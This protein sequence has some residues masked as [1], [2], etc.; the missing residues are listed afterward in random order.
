MHNWTLLKKA[1]FILLLLSTLPLTEIIGQGEISL[2]KVEENHSHHHHTGSSYYLPCGGNYY[3]TYNGPAAGE[4]L[5]IAI[6][7]E[8]NN[9]LNLNT[10]FLAQPGID[11][12]ISTPP[13]QLILAPNE[14]THLVITYIPPPVYET[15]TDAVLFI[16]D[17][18]LNLNVG[19]ANFGL[20]GHNICAFEISTDNN[21]DGEPDE[22]RS[23]TYDSDENPLGSS[24]DSNADGIPDEID[25]YTYDAAG[26]QTL[27]R[28]SDGDG[29]IDFISTNTYNL[30]GNIIKHT[31]DRDADGTIDFIVIYSYDDAGNLIRLETDREA[32]GIVDNIRT[33]TYDAAGN[34]LTDRIEDLGTNGTPG[35]LD[36]FIYTYDSAGNLLSISHDLNND[37]TIDLLNTY[38]YDSAGNLLSRID[39][40]IIAGTS[41]NFI[42]TYTYDS[43]GNIS[44]IS[45]D[46]NGDGIPD[47]VFT[48]S[49]DAE[50]RRIS[51][52]T[53]SNGDG[54]TDSISTR[55]FTFCTPPIPSLSQWGLIIFALLTMNISLFFIRKKELL[56]GE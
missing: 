21:L 15:N 38:T 49:Y 37:G 8:G 29:T 51:T 2:W 26:N 41:F 28:D 1:F 10:I 9:T 27:S 31:S 40:F 4:E 56:L 55:S 30:A 3:I 11:F 39:S 42:V 50:G 33:F 16:N 32:D 35:S 54:I 22:I 48:Y 46:P 44:S 20:S 25:T 5:T 23:F 13:D 52:S 34:R 24:F 12:S 6:R 14:E 45:R 17:C 47:T 36:I 19:L 18:S 7:N 53:D 43:A